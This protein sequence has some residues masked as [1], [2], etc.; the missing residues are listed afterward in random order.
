MYDWEGKAR[1]LKGDVLM[2]EATSNKFKIQ[3]NISK[4]D[5]VDLFKMKWFYADKIER[6]Y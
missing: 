4:Y 2:F 1:Y 5:E 6:E 3:Y